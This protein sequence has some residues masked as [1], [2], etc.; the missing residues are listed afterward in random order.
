MHWIDTANNVISTS[1]T[2]SETIFRQVENLKIN[3]ERNKDMLLRNN[4]IPLDFDAAD[5]E[6][7]RTG[8]F[9]IV[10]NTTA[11]SSTVFYGLL[12]WANLQPHKPS[13]A[14]ITTVTR[15]TSAH[16]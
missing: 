7:V 16:S 9:D 3:Q 10:R 11:C 8:L 5:F 15:H 14:K 2:R 13:K 6:K 1:A 12:A 4:D